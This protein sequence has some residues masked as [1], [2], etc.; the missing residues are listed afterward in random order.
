M[1]EPLTGYQK[2]CPVCGKEFW[3]C[4]DWSYRKTDK[5]TKNKIYYCSWSCIRKTEQEERR[6]EEPMIQ[7][8]KKCMVCGLTDPVDYRYAAEEIQNIICDQCREA[9]LFARR[10]LETMVKRK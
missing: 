7:K 1:R 4:G 9:V 6:R 5:K 2:V 8:R 3:A 10:F